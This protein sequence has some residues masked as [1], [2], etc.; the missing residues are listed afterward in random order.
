[1]GLVLNDVRSTRVGLGAEQPVTQR[2]QNPTS[3]SVYGWRTLD[4]DTLALTDGEALKQSQWVE[5]THR[6][7][8][9]RISNLQLLP[10]RSPN[11]MLPKVGV[12]DISSAIRMT[13]RQAVVGT[14][15]RDF[16]VESISESG[17]AA[18]GWKDYN[19]QLELSPR[20]T[21]APY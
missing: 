21:N 1:M 3:Q 4:R 20:I 2:A 8:L 9:Y 7:P 17:S 15:V 18:A 10:F 16:L 5:W 6:N 12:L 19:L 14:S 11:V 13:E